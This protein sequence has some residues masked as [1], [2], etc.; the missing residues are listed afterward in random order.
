MVA[1]ISERHYR[2]ESMT[3]IERTDYEKYLV[4]F[5]RNAPATEGSIREFEDSVTY[6]MPSDYLQFLRTSN[7]GEGVI[8]QQYIILWRVEDLLKWNADYE[9]DEYAPGLLLIGSNGGGEAYAYDTRSTPNCI[10]QVPF[11][12]MDLNASKY[13]AS[14]FGTFL[15]SLHSRT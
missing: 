13:V 11:I 15:T 1:K 3:N 5:N 14:D 12:G 8:G 10:V 7:G 4:Q 6:Q 9:V 2:A